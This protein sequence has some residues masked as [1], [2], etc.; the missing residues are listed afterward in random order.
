MGQVGTIQNLLP[1][2][3][4]LIHTLFCSI[5][6]LI[7]VLIKLKT[8]TRLTIA[9]MNL[10]CSF[11]AEKKETIFRSEPP[12]CPFLIDAFTRKKA[13]FFCCFDPHFSWVFIPHQPGIHIQ[14]CLGVFENGIPPP[15]TQMIQMAHVRK[16]KRTQALALQELHGAL[17]LHLQLT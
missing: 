10:H 1:G 6:I 2:Y 11:F 5:P 9:G 7:I 12:F 3:K 4:I 15:V 14:R 16:N 8:I 17:I 13:H